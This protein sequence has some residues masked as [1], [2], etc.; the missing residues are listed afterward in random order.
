MPKLLQINITANWGSTGKIAESIDLASI[1]YM[2]DKN[3]CFE[4]YIE[5]YENLIS[6]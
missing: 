6:V 1:D 5:L 3:K 4:R 2:F